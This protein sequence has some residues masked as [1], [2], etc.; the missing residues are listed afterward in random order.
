MVEAFLLNKSQAKL[1]LAGIF[2]SGA[3]LSL[4]GCA[5]PVTAYHDVE[6][7][8]IA[9]PRQAPPGADAPYPNLASVPA[10]PAPVTLAQQAALAARLPV[11][12]PEVPATEANPAALAGLTLP[13]GPPPVP[14]V[15]GLSLPAT[16]TPNVIPPPPKPVMAVVKPVQSAPVSIAFRPGSAILSPDMAN[17]LSAIAPGRGT[18][19]IL[20]A[21]FGDGAGPDAASLALGL[22][23]ARAIADALTAAGVPASA[24]ILDAE[25]A[26]SGGF[27]QLVY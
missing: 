18:S 19:K 27:V 1:E 21:G 26:G 13:S 10:A 9:Q 12:S 22:A 5:G 11:N 2:L 14:N 4:T 23:R 7:G 24:I 20:A 15:P 8:A 16:P 6:G 3:V 17:A 25:A